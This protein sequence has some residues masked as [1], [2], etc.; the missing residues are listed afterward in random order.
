MRQEY[1]FHEDIYK[2]KVKRERER[3]RDRDRGR[4]AE[5]GSGGEQRDQERGR[6]A[7]AVAQPHQL[8]VLQ[9]P[10]RKIISAIR[11]SSSPA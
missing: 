11:K 5:A 6:E 1:G 10:A 2:N 4:E 8:A 9:I 3:E 7:E